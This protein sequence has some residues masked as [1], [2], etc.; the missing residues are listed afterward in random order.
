M[1]DESYTAG[2]D[3]DSWSQSQE[4][5]N[6]L[7]DGTHPFIKSVNGKALAYNPFVR[8]DGVLLHPNIWLLQN[9]GAGAFPVGT[10]IHLDG[11]REEKL[12]FTGSQL[13]IDSPYFN[14]VQF[15]YSIS[16]STFVCSG[17]TT[18]DYV[19]TEEDI[20]VME[21]FDEATF[22]ATRPWI[23]ATSTIT[24]TAT[25]RG[26]EYQVED[27]IDKPFE[28]DPA[29]LGN[30]TAVDFI[31]LIDWFDPSD[32]GSN[33]YVTGLTFTSDESSGSVTETTTNSFS[34]PWISP[35]TKGFLL[36]TDGDGDTAPRYTIK[37]IGS[38]TYLFLEWKSGDYT[39]QANKPQYYVFRKQ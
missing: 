11:S 31:C 3:I 33:L 20:A 12:I 9:E 8:G 10:W 15:T 27:N 35:W 14:T 29:V 13:T 38:V 22:K 4:S 28:P 17:D 1:I 21:A 25:K 37:T 36:Q 32:L 30:W 34:Y 24:P 16:G 39:R 5:N 26:I 18:I 2:L 6:G 19:P 23:P 7:I